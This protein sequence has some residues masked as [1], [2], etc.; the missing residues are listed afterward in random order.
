MAVAKYMKNKKFYIASLILLVSAIV[1]DGI[2]K[3]IAS[4]SILMQARTLSSGIEQK[5]SSTDTAKMA[6]TISFISLALVI[7]GI[8]FWLISL[9]YKEPVR[10]FVPLIL[11]IVFIILSLIMV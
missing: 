7:V 10:Q 4:R 5:Q 1:V 2:A 9:K 6:D 3:G 8:L 11:L